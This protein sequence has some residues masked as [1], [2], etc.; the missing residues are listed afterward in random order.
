MHTDAPVTCGKVRLHFAFQAQIHTGRMGDR[1]MLTPQDDW[2]LYFGLELAG[3]PRDV[4][5][6]VCEIL[7]M[8]TESLVSGF[9][10]GVQSS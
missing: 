1:E 4:V 8:D 10:L 7:F 9:H 6:L 2:A 5:S 3:T